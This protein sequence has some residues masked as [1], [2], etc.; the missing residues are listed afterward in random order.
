MKL[1]WL[2]FLSLL[3]EPLYA[4]DK[5]ILIPDGE[6]VRVMAAAVR[7][8]IVENYADMVNSMAIN[9]EPYVRD[10]ELTVLAIGADNDMHPVS[11]S[12]EDANEAMGERLARGARA[13]E[14][15]R[16]VLET[17]E[18]KLIEPPSLDAIPFSK[19]CG[20]HYVRFMAH[21]ELLKLRDALAAITR[22]QNYVLALETA[23]SQVLGPTVPLSSVAVEAPQIVAGF[24]KIKT[25]QGCPRGKL[26]ADKNEQVA[27]LTGRMLNGGEFTGGTLDG[28]KIIITRYLALI[29]TLGL[30]TVGHSPTILKDLQDI[31]KLR[32]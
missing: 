1:V 9:R 6:P 27:E 24:D 2:I 7:F 19:F 21:E 26:A 13:M 11:L 22:I 17:I 25:K 5:V 30:N 16:W 32:E 23:I 31:D 20:A 15:V 4:C 3:L 14:Y 29:G 18:S 12:A 8:S 10:G 28:Y